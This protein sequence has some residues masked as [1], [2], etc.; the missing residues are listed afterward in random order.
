MTP[1]IRGV[2]PSI[3]ATSSPPCSK[4]VY[5]ASP[6]GTALAVHPNSPE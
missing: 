1:T 4:T 2:I 6:I 3:P 5:V